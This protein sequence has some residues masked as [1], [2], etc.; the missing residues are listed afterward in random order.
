MSIA[1]SGQAQSIA[2]QVS[3]TASEAVA[4]YQ[5]P[6]LLPQLRELAPDIELEIVASNAIQDLQRREADIAIR[7]VRPSQPDLIARLICET[8]GY[9]YASTDYIEAFGRPRTPDDLSNV[10]VIGYENA[11]R[12]LGWLA[13][14]GLP[15]QRSN[16]C[17]V[18]TSGVACWEM[19]KQG[20]GIGIMTENVARLTPGVEAV[21]PQSLSVQVPVWLVTHRELHTSRR[22]R[23]VF[24]WLA[25]VLS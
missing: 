21:L 3:V 25:E 16:V 11:Q 24:D 2:G 13:E 22:I 5:L 10:A 1:A 4:A 6:R 8:P 23:L 19:V 7:H 14:L 20:L 12:T 9:L 17:C 18:S 15:L